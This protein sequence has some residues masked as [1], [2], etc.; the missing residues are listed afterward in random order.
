MMTFSQFSCWSVLMLAVGFA[1]GWAW[2]RVVQHGE[3]QQ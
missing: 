1:L 2:C 3:Q